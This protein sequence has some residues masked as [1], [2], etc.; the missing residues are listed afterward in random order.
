MLNIK[1]GRAAM[2]EAVMWVCVAIYGLV[3][4]TIGP[5]LVF[6]VM[7]HLLSQATGGLN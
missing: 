4:L 1:E 2:S 3:V 5:G 6:Q 7:V